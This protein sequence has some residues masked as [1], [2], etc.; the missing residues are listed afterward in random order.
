MSF[1][2]LAFLTS[3]TV[4]PLIIRFGRL[5]RHGNLFAD[6]DTDGIQK[7]HVHPV[8]RVG[9]VAIFAAMLAASAYATTQNAILGNTCWLLL[10][11]ASPAF[12][13]GLVEDCIKRVTAATRLTLTILAGGIGFF[14]LDAG[15]TRLDIPLLDPLFAYWP[16]SLIFTVFCVGGVSNSINIIDGFN[17][18]A[19]MVSVIILLGLGYISFAVGDLHLM[20]IALTT[21][22]A[23]LGFFVWNWPKGLIF[24]GDGGAYFIGFMIA[25]LSLL[26]LARNPEVSTWCPLLLVF[27]PVFETLFSVYRRKVIRGTSPGLPDATHLHSLIFKRVIKW[28]VGSKE[29]RHITRRNSMTS[30]Y[31]WLLCSASAIPAVIFWNNT[32]ALICGTILFAATYLYH[33]RRIV[34]FKRQKR[35]ALAL[36]VSTTG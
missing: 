15:L 32:P 31:L 22:G 4:T 2:L 35:K 6:H 23:V 1:F 9:G 25:E 11:A 29:A 20:I 12:L 33:Y 17:G 30:P 13:G 19:S 34:Q 24:L 14:A 3:I 21:A 36:E 27:Y 5:H 26:L 16:V 8:P 10:L 28:T 7:V 18:L